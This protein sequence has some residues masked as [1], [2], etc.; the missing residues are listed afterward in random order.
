MYLDKVTIKSSSFPEA[1]WI[2]T[3]QLKEKICT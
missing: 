3:S 1:V 2:V